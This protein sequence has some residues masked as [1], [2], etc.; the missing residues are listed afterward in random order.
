MHTALQQIV[1]ILAPYVAPQ[2]SKV[3]KNMQMKGFSLFT[4]LFTFKDVSSKSLLEKKT[5]IKDR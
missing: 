5:Q 3:Y 4:C 1:C 2:L